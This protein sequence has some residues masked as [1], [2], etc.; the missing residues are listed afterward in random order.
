[1]ILLLVLVA[2]D[3]IVEVEREVVEQRQAVTNSVR[4]YLG[5][6]RP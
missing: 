5:E 6:R 2:M 4:L 1:M 3:G